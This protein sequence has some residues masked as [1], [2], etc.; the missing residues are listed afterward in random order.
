MQGL[1]SLVNGTYKN[2]YSANSL[3][4]NHNT[5]VNDDQNVRTRSSFF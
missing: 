3:Y 4:A 2:L 1:R 5:V